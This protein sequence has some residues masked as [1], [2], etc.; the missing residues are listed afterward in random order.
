MELTTIYRN[1]VRNDCLFTLPYDRLFATFFDSNFSQ[2]P[3][4]FVNAGNLAGIFYCFDEDR[5]GFIGKLVE[6]GTDFLHEEMQTRY[7][8]D[9]RRNYLYDPSEDCLKLF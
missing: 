5:T 8:P 7:A 6:V 2:H 4:F 3:A 1:L 9:N